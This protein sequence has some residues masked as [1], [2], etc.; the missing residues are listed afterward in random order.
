MNVYKKLMVKDFRFTK[1]SKDLNFSCNQIYFINVK[2]TGLIAKKV[3]LQEGLF[4]IKENLI[5]VEKMNH[6]IF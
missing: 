2:R 1:V 3:L 4:D 6:D 5:V